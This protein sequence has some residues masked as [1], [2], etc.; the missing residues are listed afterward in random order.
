MGSKLDLRSEGFLRV[1]MRRQ[2]ALSAAVAG[3][4]GLILAALPVANLLLPDVMA[5]RV[6]G[7]PV[8]WLILGAGLFPVLG[9]LGWLYVRRSNDLEDEA[10]GMVDVATLPVPNNGARRARPRA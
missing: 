5:T 2:L 3:V 1:L 7:A 8:S 9:V 10:I 4:L 6:A